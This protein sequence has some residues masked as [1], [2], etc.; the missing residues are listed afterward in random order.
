MRAR[1]LGPSLTLALML[2]A[3]GLSG[4]AGAQGRPPTGCDRG[5]PLVAAVG[6]LRIE[7]GFLG[8]TTV[9]SY[10]VPPACSRRA[11]PVL[12]LLHGFS[13]DHRSMLGTSSEPSAWVEALTSGPPVDPGEVAEPWMYEDPSTWR[14]KEPLD[15]ILVAPDGST[16]PGGF[17]PTPGLDGYW[18]DWNP[19]YAQ[20]GTDERYATPPPRFARYFFQELIPFV[21][22]TF[23]VSRG[24]DSRAI[25]GVSLG[26]FGAF[27]L[28]LQ[29]PQLFAS[30]G[31]ISGP[32]NFLFAP[33]LDPGHEEPPASV[34]PP[35]ELPSASL[36]GLASLVVARGLPEQLA[37][38]ASV[39]LAFGDPVADQAVYRGNM[40]REL[41]MNGRAW[42]GAS[43][44]LHLR[45]FVNDAVPR[46]PQD[47]TDV[48]AYLVAQGF[49]TIVLPMNVEMDEALGS[50]GVPRDFE[51]HPGIHS[52]VYWNPFVREQLEAQYARVAHAGS[53]GRPPPQPSRFDYRTIERRFSVWDWSFRVRRRAVEFLT[54]REVS[55][56][57]LTLQGTGVVSVR[58]P[59]AC[60]TGFR[61]DPSFEVNLGPGWPF[62]E[63]LT[64]GALPLYGTTKR[65]VLRPL[66]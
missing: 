11:C 28:G 33:G 10:Y 4:P 7:S 43:P 32:H 39:F 22:R 37:D 53:G 12:Y 50:Q 56:R 54:L 5:E 66:G 65:I 29:R 34:A 30:V 46:R 52:E 14:E 18:A 51:V 16:V 27:K 3:G 49:E 24:R 15:F 23:P 42:A 64:A 13:G 1:L 6:C 40:P 63:P 2:A 41:A 8:G 35:A 57:G 58:V 61:G 45:S 19:R 20:G 36:P 48:P 55:C 62:D 31:S 47:F 38:I 17:G 9:V 26:G 44:S 21:E 60:G 59:A 25:S